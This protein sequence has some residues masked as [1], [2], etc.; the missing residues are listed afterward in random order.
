[1]L[2]FSW[3]LLFANRV[4]LFDSRCWCGFAL[5]LWLCLVLARWFELLLR[6]VCVGLL[7]CLCFV[8][9]L[10]S[11]ALCLIVVGEL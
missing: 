11:Y 2:W 5:G 8:C 9:G 4:C 6:F 10:D 7:V 3:W 1:M